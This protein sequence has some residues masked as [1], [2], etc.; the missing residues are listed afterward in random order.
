MS[1]GFQESVTLSTTYHHNFLQDTLTSIIDWNNMVKD[2]EVLKNE[3][4]F[5]GKSISNVKCLIA[6]REGSA[7]FLCSESKENSKRYCFRNAL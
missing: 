7:K 1:V 5:S 4:N 6:L 2:Q 3:S